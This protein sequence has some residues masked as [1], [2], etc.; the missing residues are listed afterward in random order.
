MPIP[1][2]QQALLLAGASEVRLA[3][4]PAEAERELSSG[5]RP[6]VVLL[7]VGSNAARGEA[8]A[9][10]VASHP[11]CSAV[12]ILGI[13]GDDERVRLTLMNHVDALSNPSHLAELLRILEELCLDLP[14]AGFPCGSAVQERAPSADAAELVEEPEPAF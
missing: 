10:R 2:D 9:E 6:S 13:S 3:R 4:T 5:F 7:D 8:C 14:G 12:P 11:A 1:E